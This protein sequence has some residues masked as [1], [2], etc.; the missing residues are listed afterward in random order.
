VASRPWPACLYFGD[1]PHRAEKAASAETRSTLDGLFDDRKRT[2]LLTL[3][4]DKAAESTI[5]WK[6]H[7]QFGHDGLV[8]RPLTYD[9][10][11]RSETLLVPCI[12]GAMKH[13]G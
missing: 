7:N 8:C 3:S 2:A 6:R 9:N 10:K 1:G 5:E 12:S 4:F 11:P 13:T